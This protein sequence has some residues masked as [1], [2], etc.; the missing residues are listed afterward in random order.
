MKSNEPTE[1]AIEDV[2]RYLGKTMTA[3][4][5]EQFATLK[6]LV[7]IARQHGNDCGLA[8]LAGLWLGEGM[9]EHEIIARCW[10]R[11]QRLVVVEDCGA[12]S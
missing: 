5:I 1:A 3:A 2:A 12:T 7:A 10:P 11:H 8:T 4:D 9:P 6:H